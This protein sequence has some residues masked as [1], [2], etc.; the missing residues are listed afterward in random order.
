MPDE[1]QRPEAPSL[2][3]PSF[4]LK[5]R[6]KRDATPPEETPASR[7]VD[8]GPAAPADTSDAGSTAPLPVVETPEPPPARGTAP[9]VPA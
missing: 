2:E 9:A 3:V 1:Q 5:R 4:G 8:T 6:R 7:P